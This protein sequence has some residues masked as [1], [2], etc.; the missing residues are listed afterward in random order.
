MA[1]TILCGTIDT[2]RVVCLLCKEF[3]YHWSSS[4]LA[5]HIN[6][7]HPVASAATA[8]VSSE[9]VNN[10]ASHSK[11]PHQ[12]KLEENTPR[13]SKSATNRLMNVLSNWIA[14]N[15][16]S[17]NIVED[18]GLT[19]VMKSVSN[20]PSYKPPCRTTVTT[21]I[22][23]MCDGD[24]KNKEILVE[25]S[26]N[27]VAITGDH[28]TSASN[29]GYN[30]TWFC[31]DEQCYSWCANLEHCDWWVCFF[32]LFNIIR[33]RG[34]ATSSV[35]NTCIAQKS[36]LTVF[37]VLT[38]STLY[39]P[40]V[41]FYFYFPIIWRLTEEHSNIPSWWPKRLQAALRTCLKYS[42]M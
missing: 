22:S 30:H 12:T 15:C 26:P 1:L 8:N 40:D 29:H 7:K 42:G 9:D 11:A 21:K 18:E 17:I 23:K 16:R 10:L 41:L 19:E 33:S 14:M 39:G 36:V 31:D 5:Y 37:D 28:W 38:N 4:S 24:K 2:G 6:A 3:G 27:Y 13:I 25:D 35:S 20:D 34:K 32:N